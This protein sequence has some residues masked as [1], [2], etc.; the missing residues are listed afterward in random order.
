MKI[1]I[2]SEMSVP[3]AIGGG[4]VRY[5][6]LARELARRGHEVTWLSMR[7]RQSP[8]EEMID[9]VRHLHRGPR[10][11]NPPGRSPF[12]MLRYMC[13]AF[14]HVLTHHY[15]VIDCQAYAPLPA[16]WLASV[17]SRQPMVATIHNVWC[18]SNTGV[19]AAG[20]AW[21]V[22]ACESLLYRLPYK[23][24]LTVSHSSAEA[25][26]VRGVRS[27]RTAVVLNGIMVPAAP[28]GTADDNRTYDAVFVGR[29][30][31]LKRVDHV[32]EC[33]ARLA[34]H[35]MLRRAA[36]VGDGPLFEAAAR[37]AQ[38]YGIAHLVDFMGAVPNEHVLAV[39][40]SS[41][42]YLH[43][44][45]SEGL[46]VVMIEAM[47]CG[48]PVVAYDIPGVRDIVEHDKDGLLVPCLDVDALSSALAHLLQDSA[49][50]QQMA[51]AGRHKVEGSFTLESMAANVEAVYGDVHEDQL[52][53]ARRCSHH[54]GGAWL[55]RHSRFKR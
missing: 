3:Y 40:R 52:F 22:R 41:R 7:Q 43:A 42:L 36:I 14:W 21:A 10:I 8:A 9:G 31:E 26:A 4:E 23:R 46:P 15:D 25:L 51:D 49:K 18:G 13:T 33:F 47:A 50:R 2:V 32:V 6:L 37:Q 20:V 38:S 30:V 44:S 39:L 34:Q 1:L 29:L 5:G 48:T 27:D 45:V 12:A 54:P 28:P 11:E 17:L 19:F 53:I 35:S 16:V 55:L 24:I